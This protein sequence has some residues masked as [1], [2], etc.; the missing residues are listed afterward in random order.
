MRKTSFVC[1]RREHCLRVYQPSLPR[2]R[3]LYGPPMSYLLRCLRMLISSMQS[4]LHLPRLGTK[5]QL[6]LYLVLLI[7]THPKL[8]VEYIDAVDATDEIINLKHL[9]IYHYIN[10]ETRPGLPK[11]PLL[12]DQTYV[13]RWPSELTNKVNAL[14]KL[15]GDEQ[16]NDIISSQIRMMN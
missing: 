3:T 14:K 13:C 2:H 16:C 9:R 15:H 11:L 12:V 10:S 8:H 4:S 7:F 5:W 6:L 1:L